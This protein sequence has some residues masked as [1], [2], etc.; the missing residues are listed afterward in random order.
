MG[1]KN[2]TG[3]YVGTG[4]YLNRTGTIFH[5]IFFI[6]ENTVDMLLVKFFQ[7]IFPNFENLK[8]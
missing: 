2:T 1:T 4:T 7:V 6:L 3:T 5:N 8:E